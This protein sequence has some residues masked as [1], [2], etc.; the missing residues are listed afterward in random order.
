MI[1]RTPGIAGHHAT[2]R[3]E[4]SVGVIVAGIGERDHDDSLGLVEHLLRIIPEAVAGHIVHVA[5][6]ALV[7][8]ALEGFGAA[9]QL[10]DGS[11]P[12]LNK[13]EL[14]GGFGDLQEQIR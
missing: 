14:M 12:H 5:V 3:R 7:E 4:L 13:A 6:E 9:L 1:I 2:Q 8:P 10:G 11:K